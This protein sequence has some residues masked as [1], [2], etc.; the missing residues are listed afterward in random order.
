MS[1]LPVATILDAMLQLRPDAAPVLS[2][3]AEM[4]TNGEMGPRDFCNAVK[5][6]PC[7]KRQLSQP[8]TP[9][10]SS[11]PLCLPPCP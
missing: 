11:S 10:I 7:V 6:V 8:W 2:R 9:P 5:C 1:A 3:F 4:I